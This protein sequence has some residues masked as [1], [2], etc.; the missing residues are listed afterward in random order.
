MKSAIVTK[1]IELCETVSSDAQFKKCQGIVDQFIN[2]PEDNQDY[3]DLLEFQ[4]G[5][6]LKKMDGEL[7]QDEIDAFDVKCEEVFSQPAVAEFLESQDALDQLSDLLNR[8]V[9]L[10][11][12]FGRV[13]TDAELVEEQEAEEELHDHAHSHEGGCGDDCG[14]S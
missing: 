1:V 7:T 6:N 8:Y 2:N 11:F 5:L 4:R 9:E 14:C 13:P 12:E 3:Q 10:T